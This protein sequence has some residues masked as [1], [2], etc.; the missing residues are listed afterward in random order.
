MASV[1]KVHFK[2]DYGTDFTHNYMEICLSLVK[3]KTAQCLLG[4]VGISLRTDVN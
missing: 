1:N 3:K 2:N 4:K